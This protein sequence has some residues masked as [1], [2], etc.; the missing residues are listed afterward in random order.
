MTEHGQASSVF[1]RL[2]LVWSPYFHYGLF[3]GRHDLEKAQEIALDTF[4]GLGSIGRDTRVLDAGCGIASS[5]IYLA[6]KVGCRVLG[7]DPVCEQV[8]YG[9]RRAA[10]RGVG[11]L[12][13]LAAGRVQSLPARS[14]SFDVVLTNEVLCLLHDKEE[15]LREIRRVLRP[16][17]RLVCSD[18]YD[19]KGGQGTAFFHRTM[20]HAIPML[21]LAQLAGAIERAGFT[22]STTLDRKHDI[23]R[24]YEAALSR[25]SSRAPE[26]LDAI[27]PGELEIAASFYYHCMSEPIRQAIGWAVLSATKTSERRHGPVPGLP[28]AV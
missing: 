15:A 28:R 26:I 23:A 24:S 7:I 21:N 18:L 8:E 22:I 10:Q 17:G 13:T 12:V 19:S 6:S 3:D 14:E 20:S 1:R 5:A 27:G 25:L 2:E 16:G 11:G 4:A 9:L